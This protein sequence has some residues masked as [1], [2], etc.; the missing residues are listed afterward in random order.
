MLVFVNGEQEALDHP[1]TL[2]EWL[3][4]KNLLG[5]RIAVEVNGRIVP[6]NQFSD[7]NIKENDVL[8]IITAVGGG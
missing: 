1:K 8:E 3:E 6:K 2:S 4:S 5:K 7:L